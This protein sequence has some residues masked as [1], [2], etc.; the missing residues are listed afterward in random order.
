MLLFIFIAMY[1]TMACAFEDNATMITIIDSANRSV[2]L[3]YPVKSIVVMNSCAP[4]EIIALGAGDKII[5]IEQDT[6][7]KVDKGFLPGLADLPVA[8]S[9][10]EPNYEAITQLKPD[11]VI[12][13]SGGWKP[14]PNEVQERLDPFGI[15]VVGLDFYRMDVWQDEIRTLGKILG[16]EAESE[17][18]IAHFLD[19][20]D[21]IEKRTETLSLEQQKK[22]YFEGT[23]DYLTYGGAGYGC[24][25]PQMIRQAGGLDLYSEKPEQ[26][27]EVN[28]ED[29][30]KR[31][32]DVIFKLIKAGWGAGNTTEFEM[33]R[34]AILNRPELANTNALKNGQVYILSYD[35]PADEGKKFGVIFL[36]KVLYPDLFA[37]QNPMA[38]YEDYFRDYLEVELNGVFI[39]PYN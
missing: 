14:E 9:Q 1:P 6:K 5:G 39:Y 16:R 35:L 34:D 11:L 18:Y 32:P 33:V 2:E 29:V 8:G 30:A 31:N 15:K 10:W 22:V 24:G 37:D 19:K 36:S 20:I 27:F 21:L 28:P 12:T 38:F 25:V 7:K 17:I 4:S 3:P 13:L 26:Y 23:K